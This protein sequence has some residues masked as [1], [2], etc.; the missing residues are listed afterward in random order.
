MLLGDYIWQIIIALLTGNVAIFGFI[1]FLIDRHDKTKETPERIMLRALG[2]D[3]LEE[4][5]RKWKHAD[6]RT[7]DEWANIEHLYEGYTAL[8]GNGSIRKLF[9]EC[10]DIETTE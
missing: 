8:G 6:V 5:L 7:A 4:K 10:K 9:E 1:Q 3:K 2:S